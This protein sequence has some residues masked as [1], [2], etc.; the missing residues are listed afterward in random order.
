[1][2]VQLTIECVVDMDRPLFNALRS[3]ESADEPHALTQ[4]ALISAKEFWVVAICA[5]DENNDL[6]K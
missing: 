3:D 2:K 1:M 6:I 5:I 4:D